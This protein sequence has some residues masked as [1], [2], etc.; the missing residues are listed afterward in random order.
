M[1]RNRYTLEQVIC[2]LREAKVALS[3]GLTVGPDY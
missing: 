3:Q 1:S 2:I